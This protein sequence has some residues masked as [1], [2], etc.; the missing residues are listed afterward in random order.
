M[1]RHTDVILTA[2]VPLAASVELGGCFG[3]LPLPLLLC[4][5]VQILHLKEWGIADPGTGYKP[6]MHLHWML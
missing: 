6:K 2:P 1:H 3:L 4:L 5:A